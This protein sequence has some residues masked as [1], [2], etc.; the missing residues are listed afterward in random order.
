MTVKD[1]RSQS[2]A[3]TYTLKRKE[4][5]KNMN[6]SQSFGLMTAAMTQRFMRAPGLPLRNSMITS[7]LH[8]I[9]KGKAASHFYPAMTQWLQLTFS[10]L[11]RTIS[12]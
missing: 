4:R 1:A 7:V 2:Y 6:S 3:T 12:F 11:E 9:A 5:K 10:R 8:H